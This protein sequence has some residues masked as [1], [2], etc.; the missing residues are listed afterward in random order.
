MDKNRV[1]D[2]ESKEKFGLYEF[3]FY[4][5]FFFTFFFVSVIKLW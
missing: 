3:L 2:L 4:N 1:L 5:Y